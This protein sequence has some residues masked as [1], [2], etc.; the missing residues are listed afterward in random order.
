MITYVDTSSL[1]KLVIDE[2]GSDRAQAVWDAADVLASVALIVV[3]GRAALAAARRE[4]RLDAT[5]H[6]RA[7][8]EFQALTDNLTIV[9]VTEEL[10]DTA[11]DLAEA[12]SLR[13]YDAVH[14][15]AAL[16]IEATVLTS[17]DG[18]LCLAAER[19]GFHVANPLDSAG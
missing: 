9:E 18:E 1:L 7:R 6:R 3:E 4:G 19:R 10:I 14:L 13:G 16:S 5:G 12:E 11:A 15:A 2:K 8:D 17:A